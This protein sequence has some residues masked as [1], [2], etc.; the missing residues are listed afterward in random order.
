MTNYKQVKPRNINLG[1]GSLPK[2]NK[3]NPLVIEAA[4]D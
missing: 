1:G 4:H 2:L 3:S